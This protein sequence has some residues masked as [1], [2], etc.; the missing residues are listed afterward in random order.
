[1]PLEL[2]G[3]LPG[4]RRAVVV[5]RLDEAE[6]HREL[7]G[8]SEHRRAERRRPLPVHRRAGEVHG[9]PE[10]GAAR[11]GEERH[12]PAERAPDHPD[13]VPLHLRAA[14]QPVD[15]G[16]HVVRLALETRRQRPVVLGGPE[17]GRHLFAPGGSLG[18]AVAAA[19]REQHGIAPP[20]EHGRRAGAAEVARAR[21]DRAA[22]VQHEAGE[23]PGA[24]R[25]V[26]I[27]GEGAL[28]TG[29][30]DLGRHHRSLGVGRIVLD[31]NQPLEAVDERRH[32]GA[33]RLEL[34]AP[35]ARG[36]VRRLGGRVRERALPG[37]VRDRRRRD[38][39]S[40]GSGRAGGPGQ[41]R[42]S[43]ARRRVA[44]TSAARPGLA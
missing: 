28:A 6:R 18:V 11:G 8:G 44:R 25:H 15:R 4:R 27:S 20:R 21:M 22:V 41:T 26:E 12:H 42:T 13:T 30:A 2:G 23:R 33:H 7:P 32:P 35:P 3:Q 34:G 14:R 39:P 19:V 43:D 17:L 29:D 9:A 36:E 38:R 5:L 37:H 1:M 40:R 24:G 10:P 31:E 16:R